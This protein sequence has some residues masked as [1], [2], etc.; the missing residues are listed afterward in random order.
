MVT[1]MK[2]FI[3]T[4][5]LGYWY[6]HLTCCREI[7]PYFQTFDH[8]PYGK[9]TYLFLQEMLTLEQKMNAED[10]ST[11]LTNGYSTN[12]YIDKTWSGI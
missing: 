11:F 6:L 9:A 3:R 12:H 7:L 1:L 5:R 4:E 8:I 10:Y 2:K